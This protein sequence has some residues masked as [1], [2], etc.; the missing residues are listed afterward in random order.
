MQKTLCALA[1][2]C[3][4]YG[5]VQESLVEVNPQGAA[6]KVVKEDERPFGCRV[7]GDVHGKSRS[8][9]VDKARRGAENDL[10]N[11]AAKLKANYVVLE[12]DRSGHVGTSQYNDAFLG[13]KAL[14]CEDREKEEKKEEKAKG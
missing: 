9:D 7:V 4:F 5:C 8:T 13:G 12:I 14:R 2:F 10:K 11:Q 6:V 3:S 1:V